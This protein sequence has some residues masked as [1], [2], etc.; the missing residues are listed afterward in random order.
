MLWF[1]GVA[2]RWRTE[3]EEES[4]DELQEGFGLSLVDV[5]V[6][7]PLPRLTPLFGSHL[8]LSV[9]VSVP[10][11]VVMVVVARGPVVVRALLVAFVMVLFA[12][13]RAVVSHAVAGLVRPAAVMVMVV[14]VVVVP[15]G[16]WLVALLL[17]GVP[18]P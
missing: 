12:L 18:L 1:Q 9:P 11:V 14:M 2:A 8:P 6:P 13:L 16:Q 5:R 17:L 7:G 3:E 10:V 15:V 4:P